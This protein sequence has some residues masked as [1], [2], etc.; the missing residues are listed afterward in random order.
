MK[1]LVFLIPAIGFR[2]LAYLDPE[3]RAIRALADAYF[4][5]HAARPREP[6]LPNANLSKLKAIAKISCCVI[7][8]TH[9]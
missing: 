4:S 2:S 3:I 1:L 7:T 6:F 9:R 5:A 8:A